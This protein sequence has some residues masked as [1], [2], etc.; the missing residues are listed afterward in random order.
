MHQFT[1][2]NEAC[3]ARYNSLSASGR[4]I[5]FYP[6][7]YTIKLFAEITIKSRPVRKRMVRMLRDNLRTLLK[8][9]DPDVVIER[10]WDHLNIESQA[11]SAIQAQIVDLLQRTP[12]ISHFQRVH[13][14]PLAD[15]DT[16]LAH[17]KTIYGHLLAGK[18]FCVRCRRLGDHSFQS[19]DVERY[20]GGG[21]FQQC[22]TGGVKLKQPDITVSIEIRHDTFYVVE[23]D[24]SGLGGF[25]MASQDAVLSLISGGFD[26][27]VSSYLCMRRGLLTHY[28][29]FNLG[30]DAHE[31]AVKEIA[32]FLWMKYGASHRVKF[33]SVPFADVVREIQE[34]SH[35]S[36]MGVILKRMMLR[37]ASALAKKLD[38]PALVTGE[39]VAQV[40]S[41]TLVNLSVI[42]RAIDTLVLR[43][44]ALM[45]K[46]DIINMS[47]AIGTEV[48][49]KNIPE[50][51]GV[52]S[53]KPTTRA[54]IDRIEHQESQFNFG[55]LETAIA[56]SVS[57]N[58][59]EI[60][61]NINEDHTIRVL[62]TVPAG[63]IVLDIRHPDEEERKPLAL[64]TITVQKLPFYQLHNR[65]IELDKEIEY[66]LYCERGV[67][68]RLQAGFLLGQGFAQV[69]VFQQNST[70]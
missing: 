13:S 55:V 32:V 57:S 35:P 41:Q 40:S 44:L 31:I 19:G 51:C 38:V 66:L 37:A 45:H 70:R 47:R 14:F 52:I 62:Q 9:L 69:G 17:T 16:L 50:Y 60:T 20:V 64:Q 46:P 42:D 10:N 7:Q 36:Q 61:L 11:D 12:G 27:T 2:K 21:L 59:D 15:F 24:Y 30:G 6:M 34:S 43:P 28:C 65:Y 49:A 4:P 25:P 33:I 3:T 1:T 18:T 67:M 22:N 56:N 53:K 29:F 54:K 5:F 68:S 8:Q 23:Q 39:A 48:F 26:S 58:I 63:A